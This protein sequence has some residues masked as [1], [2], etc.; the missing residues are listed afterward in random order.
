MPSFSTNSVIF[1]DLIMKKKLTASVHAGSH[2][3]A[4]YRGRVTP[5]YPSTAYDYEDVATT[6]YPRYGNTPNQRA[7]AEKVAALENAEEG[8]VFSSGLG[9]ILT[10]LL[11]FMRAGD[12]GIFQA[13]LY[14]GTI[15]ALSKKLPRFGMSYTMVDGTNPESFA[16]AL[17]P[18]TRVAFIETPSNPTLRITDI[19]R[20]ADIARS[21][22]LI[23]IID[24][25]FATPVN[26]N[27]IDLGI[28]I[29]AHSGT[30]YIGGHSDISCGVVV[31]S[32]VHIKQISESAIH[33][34]GALDPHTAWLVER[35]LKTI[36]LRVRQQNENALA[37]AK[38]L[39]THGSINKVH[40]PGLDN[41]PQHALAKSQMTGGYG[42]MLSFEVN[43]DAH[44][45]MGQLRL[46]GRAISLGGV[47][48]TV[49]SPV[50]TSHVKM[51]PEERTAIGV[52]DNHVRM[53]V[54]IEDAE[55]LRAD[56]QQAL[57]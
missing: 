39:S 29:V 50:R 11:S 49:T 12:H 38:Y 5:I 33:F 47:E 6:S 37:V 51:T 14:G 56:L 10:T 32:G 40:Y 48:S 23:S 42:G 1:D 25:T 2:G 24:N 53:S 46:I 16:A 27:P 57:S 17:R 31:S 22:Q 21:H 36:V 8:L 19:R 35:S 28:D 45:F 55:D 44:Q 41:H 4:Q 34:G 3:D 9:G 13:D 20:V 54:G 26:Q 18:E 52:T 7:V 43:G 30:K 15:D